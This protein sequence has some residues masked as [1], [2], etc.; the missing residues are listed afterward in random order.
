MLSV[1]GRREE[2]MTTRI[3]H[4]LHLVLVVLLLNAVGALLSVG[5][6]QVTTNITSTSG[7][8][9]LGTT[10]SQAGTTWNIT[11]GTQ[12]G[13]N[14]FHSFGSLNVGA[15]NTANFCNA[16]G[17]APLTGIQN[18]LGR[19]TG[20]QVSKIFGT[21]QTTGFGTANLFLMNPAGW[22]FG[23]TAQLN[24]GGSFHA[25]TADYIRLA[26]G[27]RFNAVPSG[28]DALTVAA[29]SAFGFLTAP[30]GSIS[31]QTGTRNAA[32]AFTNLLQ[33]PV[34]PGG[35]T[36]SLVGGP[37][38]VGAPSGQPAAGFV[39]AP[40]GRVNLVS[41]ASAGEAAFDGTGFSVDSFQQL[42]RINI[43]GGSIVDA[44]NV[45]IR[46]GD[47]AITSATIFPE[48]FTSVAPTATSNGA[49]APTP[50]GGEVN[51]RVANSVTIGGPF[52]LTPPGI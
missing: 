13:S 47:L 6:A 46:G 49:F 9:N 21:R 52:I 39:R 27:S 4:G 14:L 26:D 8:G 37:V 25:T 31:V 33:V 40:G 45:F 16:C 24:V 5:Y 23:P 38:D 41:V 50:G 51:I 19:V 42:G 7:L 34:V 22:I 29:P 32:N 36:L 3:S 15:G 48:F 2:I 30:Q 20:N 1:L 35:A 28:A 17:S 18:I 10:V 11:G 12:K 43:M 44:K